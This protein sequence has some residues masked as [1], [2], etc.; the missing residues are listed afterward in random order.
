MAKAGKKS[1]T[2]PV[3]GGK[4]GVQVNAIHIRAGA[5]KHG[6]GRRQWGP[7]EWSQAALGVLR[8]RGKLPPGI[9]KSDLV[10]RVH[11]QLDN[12]PVYCELSWEPITRNTILAAAVEQ[13]VIPPD[14][15]A[16]VLKIV[17]RQ[18]AKL[19]HFSN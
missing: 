18:L 1:I 5:T 16:E 8:D 9:S 7:H 3:L 6:A 11:K 15:V 14:L 2:I 10:R 19:R 13:G 12:D 17:R 4:G